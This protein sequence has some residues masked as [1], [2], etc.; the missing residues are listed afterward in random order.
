MLATKVFFRKTKGGNIYKTVREHYLRDDIW[1][2][3]KI[4]KQN[5]KYLTN[6]CKQKNREC[7]LDDEDSSAKSTLFSSSYYLLLDTNIILDQI[8][9]LSENVFYNVIILQ[10]VLEEV[11]HKSPTVYKRLKE[12]IADVKRK[13]YIF[14]NEHHKETYVER[15]PGENIND[16]NDRAI[17]VATNWYNKHLNI[18]GQKILIVLL[19]DDLENKKK[20]VQENIP[21]CS[22]EEY[23]KSL[24]NSS[25]LLDK[26]SKRNFI[27]ETEGQEFFPCHLSPSELHNG[28]KNEKFFQ[29]TFSVSKENFLEG[30]V[31]VDGI[32]KPILVQGR[33]GLNRAIDGDIVAIELFPE[34]QWSTPSDIVLQDEDE[35]D[36]ADILNDE[37]E[38]N[39]SCI[40][41]ESERI[42]TGK[43]VGIIRRKWRQYCGILQPSIIQGNV[44][45]LFVPA[46]RKIP[47]V[48][49]ETRQ[50]ELLSKQR[51]IVAI[52]SWPRNS[53]YPL[54]HFVRALGNIGDKETENEILLLEYDVPHS[55]FSDAVLSFLPK[56]PWS[57]PEN[58]IAEREDLRHLDICSVDPPKCTDIDDALHCRLLPNGNY[59]VGVHIADVSHFI[60]PGTA[61][62]KE[63][64][65]RGTTVYLL[66]KRISMIPELLSNNLCSLRENEDRLTFSCIWEMNS[67]A[68]IINTRFCKSVIR[69]RRAMTYEEAQIKIDDVNQNDVLAKSLRNLNN[70]AKKLK[71]KRTDKGALTLA[72]PE[73]YLQEDNETHEPIDV[74]VKHLR[75]TNFMIEEFMLLANVSVAEKIITEFPECA[76]LRRHP[77]PPQKNFE[78]LIKAGK[79]QG[80]VI[81]T[82]SGKELAESL[83]KAEKEDNPYFNIMLRI[84]TTRCLMQA[85][86]FI[87]GMHQ[88]N[89]FYHYGLATPIY[90]HFTSP[91][92]RYADIIVHR[93]LAICIG[94]DVTCP[95]LLD[96]QQNHAL[97][98]NLNYRHRMA[99]YASRA[100]IALNIHLF[101]R[102][103]VKDEEGYILFVRKNALQVLVPKYGL[104]GT[105]YLNKTGSV[106][107]TY[108]RED[109]SQS[110]GNITFR[111]F[112]L[113]VVQL[114]LDRSN[115]QHE[116][117]IFKLV[118]PEIPGFSVPPITPQVVEQSVSTVKGNL[119]NAIEKR[120][121]DKILTENS[122]ISKKKH[123]KTKKN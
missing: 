5:S 26:L 70:F 86:Y 31:N 69:S 38:L 83:D 43:I 109:H 102:E 36:I 14:V 8:D 103:K 2:G 82:N 79:N 57:I 114:S 59:E 44:K 42:P 75:D 20:A 46:E 122:N 90:T 71:K 56:M 78:S 66:D 77:E 3:S 119:V 120:K 62:D 113:I 34:D 51:I 96:K 33:M 27:L 17:R 76:M 123:K 116:K 98:L 110:Y 87:S 41:K 60:K 50:S 112:D 99:Q 67:D 93:L 107:F 21:V 32:E 28:I 100:S 85:V 9:I 45:H 108:N 61:L 35:T 39:N 13:F 25:F 81:N 7:I 52:D 74:Q 64:A 16:R 72:S 63:A 73:I 68:N 12:I 104:E 29:G 111:T 91:I 118:K 6:H 30:S 121:S 54:G 15:V 23:I 88:Q 58:V 95:E 84:L 80:F 48:R 40:V 105:V 106:T 24:E 11:R 97:C 1:C 53:R 55:R 94:A 19:T 101:F 18:D 117:L 89:E 10:T 49:I 92:R 22:M 115:I 37:K 65:L 4:C 47:K